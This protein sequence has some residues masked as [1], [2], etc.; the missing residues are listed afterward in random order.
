MTSLRNLLLFSC[1]LAGAGVLAPPTCFAQQTLP[2]VSCRVD[3][4]DQW[5]GPEVWA[6]QEICEGRDADFN[7]HLDDRLHPADESHAVRWR[8][9]RRTLRPEFLKVVL[10]HEPFRSAVHFHGVRIVGAYVPGDVNLD[11]AVLERFLSFDGSLFEGSVSMRRFSTPTTLSFANARIAGTLDMASAEIGRGLGFQAATLADAILAGMEIGDYLSLDWATVAGRLF[12]HSTATGAQLSFLKAIVAGDVH[13]GWTTIGS[14]L[15]FREADIG[16][17]LRMPSASIGGD[18]DFRGGEFAN[19]ILLAAEIGDNLILEDARIRGS[20]DLGISTIGGNLYLHHSAAAGVSMRAAE[21]GRRLSIVGGGIPGGLDLY[22]S[23]IGGSVFIQGARL[24]AVYAANASIGSDF[25]VQGAQLRYMELTGS[26]VGG[27]LRFGAPGWEIDWV[28]CGVDRD[29]RPAPRL[30][31]LNVTADA[32]HDTV[33]TWPDCLERELEG[34]A[35]VRLDGL[36]A[37]DREGAPVHARGSER[38]IRWLAADRSF[39]LRPYRQLAHVLEE[40]GY[41][42]M[43]GDV[44]YAGRK[45]E[46]S[47]LG[48]GDLRWWVLSALP[49]HGGLRV[50]LARFQGVGVGSCVHVARCAGPAD[51]QGALPARRAPRCLVQLRHVAADHSPARN[52]LRSR[53]RAEQCGGVLLLCSQVGGLCAGVLHPGRPDGSGRIAR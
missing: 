41:G 31:L 9:G 24:P 52:P 40:A 21:I 32:L 5:E 19:V 35:Y 50:R 36:A 14:Q 10:L 6:W 20:L 22:A 45:R 49:V 53:H 11:D 1:A 51:K 23:A 44:R 7:R 29:E 4:L 34:L 13:L 28:G 43:A 18:L 38:Y 47:E 42:T 25:E 37:G 48:P 8:D 3:P 16:G 39:S 15:S 33:A 46:R 27:A 30:S 17:T 12:M 26:K 2:G